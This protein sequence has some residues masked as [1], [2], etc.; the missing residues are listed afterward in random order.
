MRSFFLVACVLGGGSHAVPIPATLNE[1][2]SSCST[3]PA[4]DH[5]G[6]GYKSTI[7]GAIYCCLGSSCSISIVNGACTCSNDPD[8]TKNTVSLPSSISATTDATTRGL[9]NYTRHAGLSMSSVKPYFMLCS[10]KDCV[11]DESCSDLSGCRYLSGISLGT[12]KSICDD[13]PSCWG[14]SYYHDGSA[15]GRATFGSPDGWEYRPTGFDYDSYIKTMY[16]GSEIE[17]RIPIHNRH[18]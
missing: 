8:K 9:S 13:L 18:V 10:D 6:S 16:W 3:G 2:A 17:V 14:F 1:N 15:G 7:N 12:A 5:A 4:C 11:N